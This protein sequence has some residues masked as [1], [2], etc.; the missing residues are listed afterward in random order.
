MRQTRP[1]SSNLQLYLNIYNDILVT[2]RF[3]TDNKI[4]HYDIKVQCERATAGGTR[5]DLLVSATTSFWRF[6]R[7]S[8][9]R[10]STTPPRPYRPSPSAS[11]T[12]G[13]LP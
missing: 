11:P 13:I 1:L 5:I 6:P 12:L 4:N 7:A 9:M 2:L 3:L 8:R 10:S